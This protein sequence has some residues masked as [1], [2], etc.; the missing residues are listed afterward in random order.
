MKNM[1]NNIHI[2]ALLYVTAFVWA[3]L[4]L[5]Q[6]QTLTWGFVKSLNY[7]AAFMIILIG[8][9]DRWIWKWN[10]LHPWF[11]STPVLVGTWKGV[12]TSDWID[13]ETGQ[14]IPP[15]NAFMLIYQTYSMITAKLITPESSSDLI[16]S[17]LSANHNIYELTGLYVNTPRASVRERSSI[18]YGGVVLKVHQNKVITLQGHY[19]T[20]RKSLGEIKFTQCSASI[21]ETTYDACADA[22]NKSN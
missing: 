1:N 10:F 21:T 17:N 12:L 20:D 16:S 11:V 8:V 3:L 9:F 14:Q 4:L 2:K 19:W 18:H 7:I 13:P 22:F 5:Y 15:V 6:G